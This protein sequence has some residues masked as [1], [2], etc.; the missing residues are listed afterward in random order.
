[1]VSSKRA[2]EL[3]LCT[4]SALAP[5]I[6]AI[7]SAPGEAEVS[8]EEV[9]VATV[10]VAPATI[11]V[12]EANVTREAT[13]VAVAIETITITMLIGNSRRSTMRSRG[14]QQC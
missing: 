12:N 8:S 1:M 6:A 9:E 11:T 7:V 14:R 10:T 2:K 3:M 5:T 4:L 13:M